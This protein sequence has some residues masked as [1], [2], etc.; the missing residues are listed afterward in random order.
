MGHFTLCFVCI[1]LLTSLAITLNLFRPAKDDPKNSYFNRHV[2]AVRIRSEHA[3]GYLKGRFASLQGLRISIR[4]L[5]HID[6]LGAW[7]TAAI[8]VHNFALT[9]ERFESYEQDV[10]FEEGREAMELARRECFEN[11]RREGFLEGGLPEGKKRREELK[12]A[13]LDYR[14]R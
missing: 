13:L 9:M 14:G 3:I 5:R 1:P 12:Q 7:I 4:S 11:E 6:Y 10:L 2:S 8:C